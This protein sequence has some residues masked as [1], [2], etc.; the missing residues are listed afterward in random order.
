[1]KFELPG[2][3]D[4]SGRSRFTVHRDQP[5]TVLRNPNARECAAE[6]GGTAGDDRSF[7][8]A[9]YPAWRR[10]SRRVLVEILNRL[11]GVANGL[12]H[13]PGNLF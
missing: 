7:E 10:A 9:D 6:D 11:L 1:M 8:C 3:E 5:D 13:F 12:L 2:R 4:A